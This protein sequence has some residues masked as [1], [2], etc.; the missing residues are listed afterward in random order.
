[1]PVLRFISKDQNEGQHEKEEQHPKRC[2]EP[3]HQVTKWAI[4]EKKT[5]SQQRNK[6]QNCKKK[7]LQKVKVEV[8]KGQ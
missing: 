1:M 8:E 3:H 6:V 2:E 7:V 5:H 4:E